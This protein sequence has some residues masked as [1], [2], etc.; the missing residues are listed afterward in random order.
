MFGDG[1]EAV[2]PAGTA[3]TQTSGRQDQSLPGT[4]A[5][6]GFHGVMAAGGGEPAGRHPPDPRELVSMDG[7]EQKAN[8]RALRSRDATRRLCGLFGM[9]A[10]DRRDRRPGYGVH[11]PSISVSTFTSSVRKFSDDRTAASG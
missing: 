6:H 10:F 4:V 5:A 3:T 11:G 1:I 7:G 2:R 8:D 9:A